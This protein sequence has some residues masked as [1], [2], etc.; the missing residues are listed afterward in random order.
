MLTINK[1]SSCGGLNPV[2]VCQCCEIV[3]LSV[4]RKHLIFLVKY[5]DSMLH[6]IFSS[7]T[8]KRVKCPQIFSM[9]KIFAPS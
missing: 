5:I 8:S 6:K 4:E 3:P 9:E 2:P 1:N 7:L